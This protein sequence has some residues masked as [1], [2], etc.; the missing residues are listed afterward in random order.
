MQWGMKKIEL[1]NQKLINITYNYYYPRFYFS[2]HAVGAASQ[3]WSNEW[4]MVYF[5]LMM[6]KYSLWWWMLVNDGEM[7]VNDGEMSIWPYSQF[8]IID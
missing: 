6:I 4:M 8:T 1:R 5:K 3:W 7:L 2:I